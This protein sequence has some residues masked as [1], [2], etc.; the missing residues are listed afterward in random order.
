MVL[1]YYR[2]VC[3]IRSRTQATEYSLFFQLTYC[4]KAQRKLTMSSSL[5]LLQ[6]FSGN[7]F[8]NENPFLKRF[9][10]RNV[11]LIYFLQH[12][13]LNMKKS[14]KLENFYLRVLFS[15]RVTTLEGSA[16]DNLKLFHRH[17]QSLCFPVCM[18]SG[19]LLLLCRGAR[20]EDQSSQSVTVAPCFRTNLMFTD[21]YSIH[22]L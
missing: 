8:E 14:F 11:S 3:T 4:R 22:E 10:S 19:C 16:E 17:S 9:T 20:V 13:F 18:Q 7:I 12:S 5:L 6:Y 15:S 21:R 1:T 2:L